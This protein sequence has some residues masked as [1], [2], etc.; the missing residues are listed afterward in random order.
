MAHCS[1][2]LRETRSSSPLLRHAK[3]LTSQGGEDGVLEELFRRLPAPADGLPRSCVEVGSWDGKW[4]SNTFTLCAQHGWRGLLIEADATRSNEAA[5]M[6]AEMGRLRSKSE[7][8]HVSGVVCLT[9]LVSIKDPIPAP[10]SSA[11]HA[12]SASLATLLDRANSEYPLHIPHEADMLSIDIDGNDLHVWTALLTDGRYRPTVVVIEFNPTVPNDV[13]FHQAPNMEIQQGSSLRALT[14]GPAFRYGYC[15]VCTTTYNAFFIRADALDLHLQAGLEGPLGDVLGE[16]PRS[17]TSLFSAIASNSAHAAPDAAQRDA[18][19]ELLEALHA[20]SMVTELLQTYEGEIRLVG[21]KKLLWHR[22]AI[23]PQKFQVLPARQRKFPFAPTNMCV[24]E[25]EAATGTGAPLKANSNSSTYGITRG[26]EKDSVDADL[27]AVK[28]ELA[29]LA[30]SSETAVCARRLE[31]ISCQVTSLLKRCL[32]IPRY[33]EQALSLVAFVLATLEQRSRVSLTSKEQKAELLAVIAL[34]SAS[35]VQLFEQQAD[36]VIELDPAE[37]LV[38]LRRAE[39]IHIPHAAQGAT[40]SSLLKRC[41]CCRLGGDLIG[42]RYYTYL[43]VLASAEQ[44]VTVEGNADAEVARKELRRM[45]FTL[46]GA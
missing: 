39:Q 42:Y 29:E 30:G 44:R 18:I 10:G 40:A 32:P 45:L 12:A 5:A 20:P 14:E 43:L 33:Q 3:D 2:Y 46:M 21:P 6:Y 17:A 4:L 7:H 34:I 9:A 27:D 38:W 31:D 41:R 23:N 19:S 37:A 35:L 11:S 24:P 1:R 25:A 15:L 26:R 36:A 22:L 13:V 28:K 16:L 8:S